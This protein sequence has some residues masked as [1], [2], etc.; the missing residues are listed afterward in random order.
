MVMDMVMA[1]VLMMDP[2]TYPGLPRGIGHALTEC[3]LLPEAHQ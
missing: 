1:M 2:F 3:L